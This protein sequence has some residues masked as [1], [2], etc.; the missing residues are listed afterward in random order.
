MRHRWLVLL[1]WV[2]LAVA[3]GA[4]VGSTIGR[5]TYT[6]STPGQP[7]Y[8]ANV[9]LAQAFGVDGAFE[10]TIAT[11]HLPGN[12]RMRTPGGKAAAQQT[13]QAVARPGVVDV[14][15]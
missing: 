6:Y 8:E 9:H 2:A 12:L 5:L 14:A 10:P 13:F 3:G 15:D 4:T 11:L 1:A 7:G